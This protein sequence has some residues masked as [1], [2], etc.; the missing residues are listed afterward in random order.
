M[1]GNVVRMVFR[2]EDNVGHRVLRVGVEKMRSLVGVIL[3]GQL[4]VRGVERMR[5]VRLMRL[6]GLIRLRVGWYKY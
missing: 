5:L 6:V 1:E 2:G 3:V 4:R